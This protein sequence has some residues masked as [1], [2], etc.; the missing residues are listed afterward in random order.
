MPVNNLVEAVLFRPEGT[1]R[2]LGRRVEGPPGARVLSKL[3]TEKLFVISDGPFV[4]VVRVSGCVRGIDRRR[5]GIERGE[6]RRDIRQVGERPA[7][8]AEQ[9]SS[10]A[11]P[12][13]CS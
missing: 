4:E 10:L 12:L 1:E 8:G 11:Q 13:L 7:G 3:M 2:T 6:L 5:E 9:M